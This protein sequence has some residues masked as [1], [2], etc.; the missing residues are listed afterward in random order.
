MIVSGINICKTPSI[1]LLV[2]EIKFIMIIIF[3]IFIFKKFN[4][5]I[6]KSFII[7]YIQINFK[8]N[9]ILKFGYYTYVEVYPKKC[10]WRVHFI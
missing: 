4:Y 1:S 10:F 8:I 3:E 5:L 7:K 9:Y 6:F 2:L